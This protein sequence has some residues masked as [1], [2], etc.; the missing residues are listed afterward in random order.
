MPVRRPVSP[1]PRRA[2]GLAA[3]TAAV[4]A[5]ACTVKSGDASASGGASGPADGA[6]AGEAAPSGW[7][8]AGAATLAGVPA[9]EVQ[10]AVARQLAGG[11][12]TGVAAD[13]WRHV[14]RLYK[15]FGGAA[16]WMAP[17]GPDKMR[18]TALVKALVSADQDALDLSRY[19]LQA[20][21]EAMTAVQ[22]AGARPTAEQVARA[23][24][25]LSSAYAALAENLL[26]GQTNPKEVSTEWF[27]AAGDERIDSALVRS[28]GD[29]D[30]S[31]GIDRMRPQDADY[32]VLRTALV[33]Y[34]ALA[35]KGN[36]ATVPAGRALLPGE[37]D[38]PARLSALRARLTAEG[39]LT[40]AAAG[41]ASGD[42]VQAE[43]A[44]VAG[45]GDAR[46]AAAAPA[47]AASG[48]ARGAKGK[49]RTA[50]RAG[51][52]VYDQAL[53]GGVATFQARH[54]IAVDSVLGAE[55]VKAMNVPV[56]YRL[57]QIATNLERH[58]WLPRDL[59]GRHVIVN[60]PA[61][62]LEAWDGGRKTLE[63]KVVVG[64][65]YEDRKTPVFAD[66]METVVFRPYWNITD[67]IAAKETF[68]KMAADPDYARRN[69]LET[70]QENGQTRI[71][72]LPGDSN[73][74]GLVKFLFPN[75]Y[76]IYLHD[77]PEKQLF[78]KDVRGFSHGCIR[79]EKPAELAQ[80]VLGWDAGRVQ[81][82]MQGEPD[83][84]SVRLPAKIPVYIA[85]FTAYAQ[86]GQLYFGNDLYGRDGQ[87]VREMDGSFGQQGEVVRAVETLRQLVAA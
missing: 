68:P 43:A 33:Q 27:I 45:L 1:A 3:L 87:T 75:Q 76:N 61:F 50:P 83:N 20:L 41:G 44:D 49:P 64:K 10:A 84:K 17:D 24:V 12:P 34:R 30:V 74:L 4:F 36:W 35:A 70:F 39:L 11:P 82:A 7:R 46:A 65:D 40:D 28:L 77:T 38:S 47:A 2:A 15:Q 9:A 51:Q 67:D 52:A 63:M 55:T 25:L 66:S 8:P 16:L 13:Q 58:R 72:Q 56:G 48:A 42:S 80:W 57:G 54:G 5:A 79:L 53:A 85:Y 69:R 59:G 14:Q 78:S 81:Q 31:R 71:R 32:R 73:S 6:A 23:D 21:A 86:G 29:P 62:K 22:G 60:V 18:A 26:T 19:P 37:G